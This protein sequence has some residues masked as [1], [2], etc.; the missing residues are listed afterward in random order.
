MRPRRVDGL[1]LLPVLF[2]GLTLLVSVAPGSALTVSSPKS[3]GT[4]PPPPPIPWETLA[5]AG[6]AQS[7]V[8]TGDFEQAERDGTEPP[9]PP[10]PWTAAALRGGLGAG[11]LAAERRSPESDGTEPPPPPIPWFSGAQARG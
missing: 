10:I 5:V 8:N 4:E 3:D 9:P 6:G 1:L 7:S 2:L 11:I